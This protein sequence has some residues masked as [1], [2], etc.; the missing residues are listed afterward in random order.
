MLIKIVIVVFA[1]LQECPW[2]IQFMRPVILTELGPQL[3][4]P[5][6]QQKSFSCAQSASPILDPERLTLAKKPPDV[7]IFQKLSKVSP[8]NQEQLLHPAH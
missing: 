3:L 1:K 5:P 7:K 2:T 4:Q 8:K 6:L